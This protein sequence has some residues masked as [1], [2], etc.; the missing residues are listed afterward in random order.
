[1]VERTKEEIVQ[2]ADELEEAFAEFKQWLLQDHISIPTD[3]KEYDRLKGNLEVAYQHLDR[4]AQR[5]R[6][7]KP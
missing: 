1:M 2:A 3:F 6:G 4:A 5:L 7:S